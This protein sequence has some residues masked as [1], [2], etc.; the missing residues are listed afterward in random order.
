M[1]AGGFAAVGIGA[2]LGA[3]LRWGL[4]LWLNPAFSALPL[5]TLIANLVGGYLMGLA[6]GFFG[7][8]NIVSPE[9]RLFIT[10]GFL[11]G[12]TTFSAFSAEAVHLFSRGEYGWA[13]VHILSHVAGSLLMTGLGILTVQLLRNG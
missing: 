3:W 2:A 4:G 6:M 8:G 12:L 13:S 5:G 10:T 9:V 11:G 1:G 7:L